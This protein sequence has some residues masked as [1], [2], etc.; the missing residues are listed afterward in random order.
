LRDSNDVVERLV[1]PLC[2]Q[3]GHAQLVVKMTGVNRAEEIRMRGDVPGRRLDRQL[4]REELAR[5]LRERF[6]EAAGEVLTLLD[7]AMEGEHPDSSHNVLWFFRRALEQAVPAR[8]EEL[9]AWAWML[10]EFPSFD[11][12]VPGV[13]PRALRFFNDVYCYYPLSARAVGI[14]LW[15]PEALSARAPMEWAA[16]ILRADFCFTS[17][18]MTDDSTEEQSE[19]LV[20][21]EYGVVLDRDSREKQR[22]YDFFREL[23]PEQ[24]Q[25]VLAFVKELWG[26]TRA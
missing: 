5:A 9:G 20:H 23:S 26:G 24:R 12:E 22:D 25:Q 16:F 17:R 3:A 1:V 10:I 4:A 11:R 14:K 6:P 7:R 2:L 18:L 21:S 8:A 13:D 15:N 19:S